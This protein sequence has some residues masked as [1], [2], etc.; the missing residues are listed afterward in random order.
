MMLGSDMILSAMIILLSVAAY[1]LVHSFLASLWAKAQVRRLFGPTADRLYRL[2]Y[3]SIAVVT[4]F[5]LLTLPVV[6]PGRTL[7]RLQPPWSWMALGIQFLAF[8]A[9][10]LGVLQTG[11]GSFMGLRQLAGPIETTAPRLVITGLYR[12][13]RHPLYTAGLVFIW[14]TPVMNT[15][16]LAFYAGLTIYIG[17][18]T[19]HEEYRLRREFGE[20]YREYQRSTPMLI[21]FPRGRSG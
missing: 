6:L 7:Y 1:G 13:V 15:N 9:L 18:G 5:P 8:L 11:A 14:V 12:F 10:V 4:L 17:V 20:A 2:V 3:N 16:L 21:P 19:L